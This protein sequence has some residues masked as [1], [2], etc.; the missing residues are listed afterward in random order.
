MLEMRAHIIVTWSLA[1][2]LAVPAARTQAKEMKETFSA[3]AVN[4]G[5]I[6]PKT[7]GTVDISIERWITDAERA[8]LRTALVE[9]G[10]RGLLTA[11]QK[12]PRVGYMRTPNSLGYELRYAVQIPLEDGGRRILLATDRRIGFLEARNRG[13]DSDYPF[14]VIEL[15]LDRDDA[16]DGKMAMAAQID[17]NRTSRALEIEYASSEPVRL[18]AVRKLR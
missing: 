11:L 17:L 13:G 1:M 4:M 7:A 8:T 10:P 3:F 15:R 9:K 12:T 6:G 18:N 14:T 5:T 2:L 16:G